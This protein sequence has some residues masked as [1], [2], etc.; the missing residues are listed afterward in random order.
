MSRPGMATPW[1][2]FTDTPL[3]AGSPR[4][5]GEG[6]HQ[7]CGLVAAVASMAVRSGPWVPGTGP[8]VREMPRVALRMHPSGSLTPRSTPSLVVSRT[9]CVSPGTGIPFWY[10]CQSLDSYDGSQSSKIS[11]ATIFLVLSRPPLKPHE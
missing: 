11:A 10:G 9:P 3:A 2:A 4:Q 5:P 7:V 8:L 6:A 1:T